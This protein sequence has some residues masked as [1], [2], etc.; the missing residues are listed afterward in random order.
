MNLPVLFIMFIMR[1]SVGPQQCG[2]SILTCFASLGSFTG[3]FS[4]G[5]WDQCPN[6]RR[7]HQ[8]SAWE[9]KLENEPAKGGYIVWGEELCWFPLSWLVHT[10][11]SLVA[12]HHLGTLFPLTLHDLSIKISPRDILNWPA[13]ILLVFQPY[14]A[15][16]WC[17]DPT[18]A[19]LRALGTMQLT[20]SSSPCPAPFF[21]IFLQT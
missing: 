11:G 21:P 7:C 18:R 4:I 15:S 5:E 10:W 3:K 8:Q 6:A 17:W 14:C 1:H 9:I 20:P 2:S 12:S 19:Q 13:L 16:C